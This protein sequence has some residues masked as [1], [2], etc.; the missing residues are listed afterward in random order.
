MLRINLIFVDHSPYVIQSQERKI[1]YFLHSPQMS[2]IVSSS[3]LGEV[4]IFLKL[5]LILQTVTEF[6]SFVTTRKV[7]MKQRVY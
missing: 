5:K 6:S 2:L 1:M 3:I 4:K 7:G